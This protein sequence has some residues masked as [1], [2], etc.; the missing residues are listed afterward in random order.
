MTADV[1]RDSRSWRFRLPRRTR[2]PV[3]VLGCSLVVTATAAAQT[4]GTVA[5]SRQQAIDSALAHNPALEAARQQIAQA[6]ARKVQLTAFPDP[7]IN[8]DYTGLS[9]PFRPGTRT[10]SDVSVG[11]TLPFPTKFLLLGRIGRADVGS[12]E[13]GYLQLE[14][15]TMSAT[16]QAYDAILVALQHQSDLD[17]GKTLAQDFLKKTE[18]RFQGGT[19]PR[20]D[21]I[22]AQVDVA[23]AA[24]NL[25][26]NQ[27][28]LATAR[29][30]LN[31]LLGRTVGG[32]ISTTDSLSV[33]DSLPPLPLLVSTALRER[34][35]LQGL[36]RERA[37]AAAATSLAKEF[38]VPDV[39]LTLEKNVVNG[40]PDSY[41][42]YIGFTLPLF[43]WNHTGGEVAESRHHESELAATY[44]DLEAQVEQD[45]RTTY[46]TAATALAQAVYLRDELLP[47]AARAYQI[48][49]QS[50][51]LGGSSSLEVLDARRTMLEAESQYAEALGA[52]ND[53]RADLERAI[54]GPL[55][56][57]LSGEQ[58]DH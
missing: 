5:L 9:G 44:R 52:A 1:M 45:V 31:R 39:G 2:G 21:V 33:P 42:T 13:F 23:Q 27:R 43:F 37:G 34:P 6:R 17:E 26:A 4:P 47:E 15:Q 48:A 56:T 22:K 58:H 8:G 54:G 35:E 18:A 19:V 29:A 24:N 10:G 25:L 16:A 46:A 20:L 12:A 50:Y 40:S 38:W 3:L 57:V 36:A 14:Q 53:A 30:G 55:D 49:L 7:Q 41:T 11:L 32:G 51:G 28:D